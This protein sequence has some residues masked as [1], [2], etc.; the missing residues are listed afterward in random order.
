VGSAEAIALEGLDE[1]GRR[2]AEA[3]RP[4]LV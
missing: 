4:L 2:A 1:A 3:L